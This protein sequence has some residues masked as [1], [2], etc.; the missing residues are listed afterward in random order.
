M[1]KEALGQE[2]EEDHQGLGGPRL[3][4]TLHLPTPD[5]WQT[6]RAC[7]RPHVAAFPGQGSSG[8]SPVLAMSVL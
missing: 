6:S 3:L 2:L 1:L 4:G 5:P 8:A 7:G